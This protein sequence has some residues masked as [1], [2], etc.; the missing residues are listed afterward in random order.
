MKKSKLKSKPAIIK[1][2]TLAILF[3]SSC[4][5]FACNQAV[6]WALSISSLTMLAVVFSIEYAKEKKRNNNEQIIQCKKCGTENFTSTKKCTNC[7]TKL[8]TVNDAL[9]IVLLIFFFPAGLYLMWDK[10]NW[11]KKAKAIISGIIAVFVVFLIIGSFSS[12]ENSDVNKPATSI[13]T[14]MQTTQ[15]TS[16]T[17]PETATDVTTTQTTTETTT[18][19]TTKKATTTTTKQTATKA[20]I[21]TSTTKKQ[22]T[23]A[24]QNQNSMGVYRTPS[25]KRYH[26]ISTCGGKNSYSVSLDEAKAAGLT[27]CQK[28]VN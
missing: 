6:I 25:G 14:T 28:C 19:T 21:T 13:T 9:I 4:I 8:Y 10:T 23:A 22:T 1:T 26:Y 2:V 17:A 24:A 12:N 27:P 16:E 5:S 18:Q 3:L 20:A 15:P 7:R 11:S